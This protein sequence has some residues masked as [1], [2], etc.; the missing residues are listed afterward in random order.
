M[1]I[2]D[3]ATRAR[4][5]ACLRPSAGV[6]ANAYHAESSNDDEK[7]ESRNPKQLQ[8]RRGQRVPTRVCSCRQAIGRFSSRSGGD[9]RAGAHETTVRGGYGVGGGGIL[10]PEGSGHKL[11]T[12]VW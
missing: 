3:S 12:V 7:R 4:E 8:E 11:S 5:H 10:G 2:L 1:K 9:G 6:C